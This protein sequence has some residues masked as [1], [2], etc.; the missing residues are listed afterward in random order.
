MR[1]ELWGPWYDKIVDRL[2]LDKKADKEAAKLLDSFLPEPDIKTIGKIIRG[3]D[4]IVF[5]AGPSLEE[6][7]KRLK[8]EGY[9]NKVLISADGA[10]SA[11]M[12]YRDPEI[13]ATDLDGAVD[14]QLEAWH[15]GSWL[16]VHGHGDNVPQIR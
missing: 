5:G 3:R 13:I 14:D 6:D 15:R 16:V 11:V 4:C 2:K 1:W 7:L 8:R 9:L 10:T 12:K